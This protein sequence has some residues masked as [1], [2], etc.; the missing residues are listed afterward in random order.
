M[1]KYQ[2]TM[3]D[4]KIKKVKADGEI[5]RERERGCMRM[6][7]DESKIGDPVLHKVDLATVELK[8]GGLF[9]VFTLRP[10]EVKTVRI[11]FL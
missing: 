8:E 7:S 6:R 3:I 10:K 11:F 2:D 1:G 9:C 4:G 5:S